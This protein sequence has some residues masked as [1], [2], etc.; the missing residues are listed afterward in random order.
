MAKLTCAQAAAL[1]GKSRS[2]IWRAAKKGLVSAEKTEAGDFLIDPAELERVYGR[3]QPV[4]SSQDVA[5]KQHATNETNGLQ[6]EVERLREQIRQL[7]ED[8]RDLR[9]ERDRMTA[10]HQAEREWLRKAL[11]DE[12]RERRLLT[13]QR[14]TAAAPARGWWPFRG[15][16]RG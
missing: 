13:D 15:A 5:V 6:Q 4:S 12:R 1:T 11:D 16:S 7:E 8:K 3:L 10:E 14:A 9:A 2:T